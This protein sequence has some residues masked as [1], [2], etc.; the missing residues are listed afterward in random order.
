MSEIL[1]SD[2]ELTQGGNAIETAVSAGTLIERGKIQEVN[3]I[4]VVL[5][6]AQHRLVPQ[7][8][9]LERPTRICR[10]VSVQDTQSFIDYCNAH[11]GGNAAVFCDID[12]HRISAHLDYHAQGQASHDSHLLHY[13][14]IHTEEWI[15]WRVHDNKYL[16]Q[17]EF[18]EHIEDN[19]D[20][21]VS[22]PG[23]QL[24]EMAQHL[25]GST[26]VTFTSGKRIHDG[27]T[28]IQYVEEGQGVSGG[29]KGDITIPETFTLGIR[30]FKGTDTYKLEA[31]FRYRIN[32]G[33]LS[34]LYKLKRPT[35]VA[36][37]AFADI[38]EAIRKS[39][40]AALIVHA[41]D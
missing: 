29:A 16:P 18:A 33:Q 5:N 23:A 37:A 22:P 24:L 39:T 1:S 27:R 40:E 25:S 13:K 9:L 3:G 19:L 26:K 30:P 38:V 7:E 20:E 31:R 11:A 15:A 21:I 14:P 4:P 41:A 36:D 35:K 2:L 17:T 34:M 28:Q 10:T 32:N 6:E 8:H 12:Q